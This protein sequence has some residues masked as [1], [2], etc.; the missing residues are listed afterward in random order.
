[1]KK[2]QTGCSVV[3]F[4]PGYILACGVF[5]IWDHEPKYTVST[6]KFSGVRQSGM[7]FAQGEVLKN[8]AGKHGVA[9][10]LRQGQP[11]DDIPEPHSV[12]K[13]P[14]VLCVDLAYYRKSFPP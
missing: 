4:Q 1:V 8:M 12:R 13:A 10:R 14:V 7:Q 9:T 3:A 2:K 5:E 6:K 11:V